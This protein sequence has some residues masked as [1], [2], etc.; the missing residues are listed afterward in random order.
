VIDRIRDRRRDADDANL[1]QPL[2]AERIDDVVRLIDED[3]L[4]VVHVGV[5]RD[6]IFGNVRIHDAAEFVIEDRFFVQRHADAPNHAAARKPAAGD[7]DYTANN[8]EPSGS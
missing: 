4:D 5:H 2:D 1:A 3:H 7:P 6:M 8:G